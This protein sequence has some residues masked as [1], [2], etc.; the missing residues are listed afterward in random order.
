MMTRSSLIF[1]AELK[2]TIIRQIVQAYTI[3]MILEA[4]QARLELCYAG[5]QPSDVEC[6]H[7]EPVSRFSSKRHGPLHETST[8]HL[9]E[10]L[11]TTQ[12]TTETIENVIP[13]NNLSVSQVS[14]NHEDQ[15][16]RDLKTKTFHPYNQS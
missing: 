8:F 7:Q 13:Q 3:L 2:L 9:Q 1:T 12:N 5:H 4:A 6:F 10:P 16:M 14:D 15:K 11:L